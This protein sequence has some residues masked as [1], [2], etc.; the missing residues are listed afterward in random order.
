MQQCF[1]GPV[2]LNLNEDNL[3]VVTFLKASGCDR[4]K[5][6]PGLKWTFDRADMVD[7]IAGV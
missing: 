5:H 3:K 7:E 4:Q 6:N 1:D 2:V